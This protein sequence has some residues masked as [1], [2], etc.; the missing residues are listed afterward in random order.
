MLGAVAVGAEALN[1]SVAPG[2]PGAPARMQAHTAHAAHAAEIA[3]LAFRKTGEGEV[4]IGEPTE[5]V[6]WPE[7]PKRLFS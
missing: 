3:L 2:K 1:E 4:I 6:T 5:C 7:P